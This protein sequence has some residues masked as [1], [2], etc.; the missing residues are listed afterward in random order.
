MTMRDAALALAREGFRVFPVAAARKAPPLILGWQIAATVDEEAIRGWWATWPDANIGIHCDGLLVLDV[1]AKKDGYASLARLA[2]DISLPPTREVETPGGGRHIYYLTNAEIRNGVDVYGPG[3]D[4][5]AAHGYVL[6]PAS[7]T[8]S[9]VYRIVRALPVAAAPERLVNAVLR[10]AVESTSGTAASQG[11]A[12]AS[13]GGA[14]ARAMDFLLRHAVAVQGQGG[15]A[16][17]YA[18]VCRVRD[19]GVIEAEALA[20]LASWNARCIPPWDAVELSAKIRNAYA[21]GQNPPGVLAPEA[22]GFTPVVSAAALDVRRQTGLEHPAD[23]TLESVLRSEY[24]IKGILEK[25][26]NIVLF[27]Q[28]NVGKSFVALDIAASIACGVT[29]CGRKVKQGGVLYLGYEGVRA[30]RKRIRALCGKYPALDDRSIPLEW[31]PLRLPLVHNTEG[32]AEMLHLLGEFRI[33]HGTL[34]SLVIVDPLQNA[35][36]GDDGDAALMGAL[37]AAVTT[38]IQSHGCAVL[39]VHHSGHG[40]QD[41]ARGHSSLPAGVDTEIKVTDGRIELTKQ[42]DDVRSSVMFRLSVVVL[43][44]D[45]DG[46][47]VVT[48]IVEQVKENALDPALT[49]AQQTVLEAVRLVADDSGLAAKAGI[50]DACGLKRVELVAALRVLVVKQYLTEAGRTGYWI[51]E[52]GA[53][54]VFD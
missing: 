22:L 53:A 26:S 27:G 3:I 12:A 9:G 28:W 46:E 5:R 42:R 37:N 51:A 36:G 7:V 1:D 30:L 10:R 41:R 20:I 43:G 47:D 54:S 6:A 24:L 45:L 23:I 34:P 38:L 15:D 33:K 14:G 52:R 48:C 17:T 2:M 35:L 31:A 50:R 18:T 4:V 8:A 11:G 49:A 32:A 29:W 13:Q 40:N 44:K 25:A 16:H 21:Y 39:R 19:F